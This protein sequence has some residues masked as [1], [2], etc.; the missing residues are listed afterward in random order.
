MI[1]HL[2]LSY[3]IYSFQNDLSFE[4]INLTIKVQSNLIG[5]WQHKPFLGSGKAPNLSLS[6]LVDFYFY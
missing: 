1:H 2:N 4:K 6:Y 3:H 5:A